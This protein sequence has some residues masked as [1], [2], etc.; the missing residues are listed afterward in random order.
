MNGEIGD[1]NLMSYWQFS[2]CCFT[3]LIE[4]HDEEWKRKGKQ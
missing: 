2:Q 4:V 3:C 1:V